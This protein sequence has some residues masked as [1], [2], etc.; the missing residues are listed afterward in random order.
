MLSAVR[1]Q[2]PRAFICDLP[3]ARFRAEWAALTGLCW[4]PTTAIR[5]AAGRRWLVPALLMGQAVAGFAPFRPE[6]RSAGWTPA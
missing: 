3:A 2:R 1:L 4:T 5:S 6:L